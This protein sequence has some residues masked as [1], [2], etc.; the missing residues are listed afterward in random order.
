LNEL[1]LYPTEEFL[2]DGSQL[3]LSQAHN[4][5]SE[6]SLATPK[7]NLQFLTV[8]DHLIRNFTLFRLE[9]SFEIR[10]DLV[11]AI[12]RMGPREIAR[13][14]HFSGWAR[15]ALPISRLSVEEVAKPSIGEVIPHHVK[16]SIEV[17]Y[18]MP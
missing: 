6:S 2:W 8:H 5:W 15:M 17:Q 10:Q 18:C 3:P 12:K 14:C 1:S 16:C 11:D 9:T 13:G 4:S 7:L